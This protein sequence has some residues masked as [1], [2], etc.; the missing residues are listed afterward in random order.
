MFQRSIHLAFGDK[1]K[2]RVTDIFD[3][4]IMFVTRERKTERRT[5]NAE[6]YRGSIETFVKDSMARK[7]ECN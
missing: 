1:S 2:I 3:K 5:L 4:F 6:M 7:C